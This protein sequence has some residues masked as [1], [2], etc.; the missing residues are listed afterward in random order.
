MDHQQIITAIQTLNRTRFAV[1]DTIEDARRVAA[2]YLA[3]YLI[4]PKLYD[5]RDVNFG[6]T[7][8]IW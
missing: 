8:T 1:V 6:V 7:L 3:I 4:E 5:N 2:A